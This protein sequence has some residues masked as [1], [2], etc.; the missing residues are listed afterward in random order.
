[1]RFVMTITRT[2]ST[3]DSLFVTLSPLMEVNVRLENF[4]NSVVKRCY[5]YN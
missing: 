5:E 2:V 3:F 1:M 4:T